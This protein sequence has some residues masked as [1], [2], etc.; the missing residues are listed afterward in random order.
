[1]KK[2]KTTINIDK[3]LWKKFSHLVIDDKGYRKK[4][5]AIEKLIGEYVKDR[6]EKKDIVI[7]KAIIL[8]AGISSRLRPLTNELPTCLLKINSVTLL[9]HQIKNF[10]ECGVKEV[11]IVTGYKAE[12]IKKFCKE[13]LKGYNLKFNFAH[14]KYYSTT[15][16]LFSLWLAKEYM[17]EGFVYVN[18]DIFF[19]NNILRRLLKCEGDICAGVEKKECTEEDMKAK[20]KNGIIKIG[21]NIP[22]DETYGEFLGIV[23]FS[24]VG[25]EKLL[26]VLD[27]IPIDE[28]KRGY[29]T[30]A[31]QKLIDEDNKVHEIETQGLFWKDIDFVEDLNEV[32]S[33]LLNK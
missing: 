6:Y 33:Y 16:I 20:V 14:N 1:M 2:V 10:E 23:K 5:E 31:I 24:N 7:K 32:R 25:V 13:N 11:I 21:K 26:H 8:A 30:F 22:M 9:E 12:K 27:K 29:A 18:S 15:N 28:K 3:D 17:N 19:D 4:N